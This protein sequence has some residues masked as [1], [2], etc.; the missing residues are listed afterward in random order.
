MESSEYG[1]MRV[2]SY[3][4]YFLAAGY[5]I[6]EC[7]ELELGG[8]IEDGVLTFP[9]EALLF[10]MLKFDNADW[11]ITDSDGMTA[12]KL[13]EGFDM[14]SGIENVAIEAGD[15]AKAEYFDLQGVK[16]NNPQAGKL[17]IKRQGAQST[18]VVM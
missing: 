3:V 9:E 15:G 14:T 12:I 8:V 2:N 17:Y 16:V 7:I 11:W 1:L 5:M 10:S 18:K 4:N 6:E 13:P